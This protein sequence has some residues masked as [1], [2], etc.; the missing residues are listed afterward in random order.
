ME[1]RLAQKVTIMLD[2]RMCGHSIKILGATLDSILNM[3]LTQ[4]LFPSLASIIYVPSDVSIHL[5]TI[6][7]PFLL[8]LL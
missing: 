1:F 5:W 6:L 4:R 3:V 7:W 2:T 8:L